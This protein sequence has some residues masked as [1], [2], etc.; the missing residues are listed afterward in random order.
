MKIMKRRIAA[1]ER[2]IEELEQFE[3]DL[4]QEKE[5]LDIDVETKKRLEALCKLPRKPKVKRATRPRSY[6]AELKLMAKEDKRSARIRKLEMK[7]EMRKKKIGERRADK[8]QGRGIAKAKA[9]GKAKAQA[10][11]KAKAKSKAK[12]KA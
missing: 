12:A 8:M 10:K 6:V 9:K 2:V 5:Q 4:K 7:E 11:G 1:E 3:D